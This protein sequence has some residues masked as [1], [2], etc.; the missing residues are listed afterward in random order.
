MSPLLVKVLYTI[1]VL[2]AAIVGVKIVDLTMG[3]LGAEIM[4]LLKVL[5]GLVAIIILVL[6]WWPMVG[7]M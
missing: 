7:G 6:I 1:G 3:T 4:G 5:V 2:I